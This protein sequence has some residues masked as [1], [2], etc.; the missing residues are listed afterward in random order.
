MSKQTT[1]LVGLV[2]AA[3]AGAVAGLLLAPKKG[4]DLRKDIK[5]KADDFGDRVKHFAKKGKNHLNEV[6]DEFNELKSKPVL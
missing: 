5:D 6:E 1:Y 3:A 4:S 2:A